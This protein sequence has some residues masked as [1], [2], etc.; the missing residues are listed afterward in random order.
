MADDN[1]QNNQQNQGKNKGGGGGGGNGLSL[2]V[3]FD[4]GACPN[5]DALKKSVVDTVANGSGMIAGT[6]VA[7]VVVLFLRSLFGVKDAAPQSGGGGG[8]GALTHPGQLTKAVTQL[9]DHP[10]MAE[11][12][13]RIKEALG[14]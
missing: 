11:H 4:A 7:G 5:G 6:V 8:G 2:A 14:D 10:A 3:K 1:Q 12:K 9:K 13:A